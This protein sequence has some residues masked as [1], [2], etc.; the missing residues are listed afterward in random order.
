M[1]KKEV[2]SCLKNR[3]QKRKNLAGG[4]YQFTPKEIDLLSE[5]IA[6]T[7]NYYE[8]MLLL[9]Q[10][11]NKDLNE[12]VI[13]M[14]KAKIRMLDDLQDRTTYIGRERYSK[15]LSYFHLYRLRAAFL[16]AF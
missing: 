11:W 8:G 10:D 13:P 7:K 3:N 9:K 14:I 1:G 12:A 15:I 5:C 4:G 16:M 2:I 6:R